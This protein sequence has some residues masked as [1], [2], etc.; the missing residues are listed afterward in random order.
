MAALGLY[1]RVFGEEHK[2]PED[3]SAG[4]LRAGTEQPE[5]CVKQLPL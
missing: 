4:R 1:L 3:G 5:D 2:A